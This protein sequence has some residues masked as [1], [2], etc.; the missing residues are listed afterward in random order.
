MS[1]KSSSSSSSSTSN[2]SQDNRVAAS[3]Q[4]L[5]LGAGAS[6]EI[7]NEFSD[8]VSAAYKELV[9]LVKSTVQ[10]AGNIVQD[11]VTKSLDSA[12]RQTAGAIDAV[13]A[14]ATRSVQGASSIYTDL[15]PM[16]AVVAVG[17][18]VVVLLKKR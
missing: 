17:I 7:N 10:G 11:S 4:A 15:F 13:N 3:E 16:F 6:F 8:T 9:D 2:L 14:A 5:A 18:L 1:T 12:N